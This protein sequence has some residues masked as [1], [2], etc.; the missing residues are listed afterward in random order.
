[1]RHLSVEEGCELGIKVVCPVDGQ[2]GVTVVKVEDAQLGSDHPE[3]HVIDD[4]F[5]FEVVANS[6]GQAVEQS[7]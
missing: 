5:A 7:N 1:M 6:S 2:N 3:V 4:L